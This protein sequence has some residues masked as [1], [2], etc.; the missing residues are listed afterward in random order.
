MVNFISTIMD[1]SG[2]NVTKN[3]R[4]GNETIDIYGTLRTKAGEVGVVVACKNYEEPWNVGL[5][6]LK[7]MEN[8]ARKVH[9]SKIIIFTTSSYTHGCALYA[10]KRNI[11]LVDRKGLIKIAKNYAEK[12]NIVSEPVVSYDDEYSGYNA[13]VHRKPARLDP[14]SHGGRFSRRQKSS[15]NKRSSNMYS[16]A[17]TAY[18]N[19]GY[20]NR[21]RSGG[22][23]SLSRP[24]VGRGMMDKM[25][26]AN[27]N[28]MFDLY[29]NHQ[30]IYL[31]ILIILSSAVAYLFSLVT[32]GP[33]TGLGKIITS[34]II[35]FG[36][37]G[38]VERN[39]SNLIFKAGIIFFIS[40]IISIIITT[41]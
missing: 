15:R 30:I 23:F 14:G 39:I 11:K 36:G 9:A 16:S 20:T 1:D 2:F 28:S 27:M 7:D 17:P 25:S 31:I 3:Y 38:L 4:V 18:S 35:C 29:E 40:I 21:S 6:V 26:N 37:L 33:Y 22:H 5:D 12:R 24:S 19:S 8:L 41:M 10:Q 34:A 13:P 32:S